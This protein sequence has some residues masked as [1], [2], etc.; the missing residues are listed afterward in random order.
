MDKLIQVFSNSLSFQVLCHLIDFFRLISQSNN[1]GVCC[2]DIRGLDEYS[3][4]KDHPK[5]CPWYLTIQSRDYHHHIRI[6][7]LAFKMF[8]LFCFRNRLKKKFL[9]MDYDFISYK[10]ENM[11]QQKLRILYNNTDQKLEQKLRKDRI[12]IETYKT[13]DLNGFDQKMIWYLT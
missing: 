8:G 12:L 10:L 4:N 5:L 7:F 2:T 3:L 1:H 9:R 13:I 11:G 6:S